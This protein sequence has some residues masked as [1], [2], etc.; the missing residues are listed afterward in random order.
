[1]I[2]NPSSCPDLGHSWPGEVP[3]HHLVL[4]QG[5]P[6]Y[7]CGLRCDR[8]GVLQ[9]C[10]TVAAGNTE[11]RGEGGREGVTASLLPGR[12]TLL[13]VW[14]AHSSQLS[15][16]VEL[17]LALVS[18]SSNDQS[19]GELKKRRMCVPFIEILICRKLIAMPARMS[20]SSWLVTSV[21]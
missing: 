1:M 9:Q 3:H 12:V 16:P 2:S 6:R 5:S 17:R 10:Q 21:T 11:E 7:H 20:I 8:P 14:L 19:D 13:F 4:L 15:P 18:I